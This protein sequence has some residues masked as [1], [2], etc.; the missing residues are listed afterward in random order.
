MDSL[1]VDLILSQRSIKGKSYGASKPQKRNPNFQ[2][3]KGLHNDFK[4]E[5]KNDNKRAQ[6]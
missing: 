5:N 3:E 4:R 1:E 6:K 2:P